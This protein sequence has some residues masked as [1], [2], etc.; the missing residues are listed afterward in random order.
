V[1]GDQGA[2][3]AGGCVSLWV[4]WGGERGGGWRERRL[5]P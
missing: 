5:T 1:R 3:G 4:G 2:E